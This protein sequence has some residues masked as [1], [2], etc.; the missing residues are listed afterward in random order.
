MVGL[1]T[2]P[3]FRWD[4]LLSHNSR[5][6][7]KVRPLA[8]ALRDAGLRVWFDEWNIGPGDDIFAAVEHGLQ[9]TRVLVLCMTPAAFGSDWVQLE[10]GT[11]LFRDPMNRQRRF[12]PALLEDCSVPDV[13][14]RYL[15]V[16][17]RDPAGP[18]LARL[19]AALAAPPVG[20]P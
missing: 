9:H 8:E 3:E 5:D 15:Y 20:A 16:D 19:Q 1:Q 13:L 10:R 2:T 14:R 7:P 11:A 4:V 6:K 18:G 17:L 12:I